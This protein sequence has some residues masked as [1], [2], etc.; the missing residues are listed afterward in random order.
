M[1]V[2]FAASWALREK[3]REYRAELA[4][5]GGDVTSRWID[6][7]DVTG[8]K[9]EDVVADPQ[10]AIAGAT[11]DL[12]DIDAAEMV[13]IFTEVPS[14]TGGLHFEFGYAWGNDKMV[15]VIGPQPNVFFSLVGN[16][17]F[18]DWDTFVAW[19]VR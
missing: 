9:H 13:V 8:M 16:A 19:W 10:R 5:M 2:Y 3:M 12:S 18:P 11:L 15:V 17:H 1:K 14:T 4:S 7:E 6:S